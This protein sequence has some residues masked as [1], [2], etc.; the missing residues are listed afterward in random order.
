MRARRF[1]L[2][3]LAALV[4]GS[5]GCASTARRDDGSPVFGHRAWNEAPAP[6]QRQATFPVARADQTVEPAAPRQ[7]LAR[8]FPGLTRTQAEPTRVAASRTA[9]TWFGLRKPRPELAPMSRTYM[10]DA[11]E[12]LDRSGPMPSVLPVALQVPTQPASAD[13]QVKMTAGESPAASSSSGASSAASDNASK[14]KPTVAVDLAEPTN[15]I[16]SSVAVEP[17][18]PMPPI[19]AVDPLDRPETAEGADRSEVSSVEPAP[20][21]EAVLASRAEAGTTLASAEAETSPKPTNQLAE[22]S[23]KTGSVAVVL[24]SPQGAEPAHTHHIHTTLKVK[25]T[26]QASAGAGE[27]KAWRRPCLRRLVRRVG[28]LGEFADPPTAAPH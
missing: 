24:P 4:A 20:D 1:P 17:E 18:R 23:A 10:T 9:P 11:R 21:D 27:A 6:P 28:R 14:A 5:A 2:V 3:F 13:R 25:P 7:G 8:Y 12:H 15:P 22:T 16:A 26:P 19:P